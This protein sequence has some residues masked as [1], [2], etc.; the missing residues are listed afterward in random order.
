MTDQ[1][2]KRLLLDFPGYFAGASLKDIFGRDVLKKHVGDFPGYFAGASLKD[3]LGAGKIGLVGRL[4][5]LLRRGLI[6]GYFV[7]RSL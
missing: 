3:H 5:R 2:T 7:D 6:E 4:P 1:Q